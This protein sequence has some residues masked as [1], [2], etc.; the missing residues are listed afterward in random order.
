MRFYLPETGE[1]ATFSVPASYPYPRSR[2]KVQIIDRT[3]SGIHQVETFYV[4]TNTLTI[5]F[6]DMPDADYQMLL[7]WFVNVVNGMEKVFDREDDL[8]DIYQ[9]RFIQPEIKAELI[10]YD[11]WDVSFQLEEVESTNP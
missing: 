10:G 1:D 6:K 9:V 11:L 8:H 2:K 5:N 4:E 7:N 3:A